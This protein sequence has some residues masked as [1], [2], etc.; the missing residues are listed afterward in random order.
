MGNRWFS[1]QLKVPRFPGGLFVEL[2]NDWSSHFYFP[3][4]LDDQ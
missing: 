3:L 2:S 1:F 4:N